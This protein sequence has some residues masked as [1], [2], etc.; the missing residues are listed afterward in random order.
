MQGNN[1]IVAALVRVA[2]SFKKYLSEEIDSKRLP[3][4][5][6]DA[7]YIDQPQSNENNVS[8]EIKIDGNEAPMAAAFEYGSG[9][10]R[11]RG[12]PS[13]ID[14]YPRN[15]PFLAIPRSR[16]PSY[17]PPPDV[18]PVILRH[19]QHPGIVARPFVLPA[20]LKNKTELRTELGRAF[21]TQVLLGVERETVIEIHVA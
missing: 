15:K 5:I 19:V 1:E 13:F 10:H 17:V 7:I 9:L 18:D 11:T 3:S 20:I 6:K 14:I 21:K 2:I 4:L 12:T 8:I 16:W